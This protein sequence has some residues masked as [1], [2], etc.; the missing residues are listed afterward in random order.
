M[1]HSKNGPFSSKNLPYDHFLFPSLWSYIISTEFRINCR[2]FEL[3]LLRISKWYFFA[4]R[5]SR[6]FFYSRRTYYTLFSIDY[7]QITRKF[8]LHDFQIFRFCNVFPK[9][10]WPSLSCHG[11]KCVTKYIVTESYALGPIPHLQ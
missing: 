2:I 9:L 11:S 4:A 1:S 6:C 5:G 8:S 7:K 3:L 10:S